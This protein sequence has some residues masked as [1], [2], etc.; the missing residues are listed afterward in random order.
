MNNIYK[1]AVALGFVMTINLAALPSNAAQSSIEG[2]AA[3]V[4]DEVISMYD[5]AQRMNLFFASSGIPKTEENIQR[6]RSQV[7]RKL[8]DEKMQIQ[9][10]L[11]S[12]IEISQ[13]EINNQIVRM[14]QQ[15]GR[16]LE[17]INKF[18]RD[19]GIKLSAL[20][21]QIRAEIA[22]QQYVRRKYSS[23][24]NISETEID[25]TL[26]RAKNALN[27]T[28]Y[29][30]S[31]ILLISN[32]P[33]DEPQTIE[34]GNQLV[35]ELQ[36]GI[37]FDSVARQFSNATSAATGGRIGW[38]SEDQLDPK[39][40]E[41]VKALPA[42]T[43]SKP[44]ITSAGIYIL[45]VDGVQQSGGIDPDKHI[46]DLLTLSFDSESLSLLDDLERV[47]ND[48]TTCKKI[49][50]NATS[51]NVLKVD[52]TGPRPVGGYEGPLKSLLLGLEAGEL[53]PIRTEISTELIIVCD[54]KDDQGI[55]FSREKIEDNI[56][57]QR[58][59][60]MSRRQLRELRKD[61]VVEY[62]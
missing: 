10:A 37:N 17:S 20:E 58:M 60:M 26:E 53:A 12:E 36:K 6:L 41:V 47:K 56:Y 30:V 57:G 62:R 35:D 31:E 5:V 29:N 4:N 50:D 13:S 28:R 49:E 40:A 54:R 51:Y 8:V 59:S 52:R 25:E 42:G 3:I 46:F 1:F 11:E 23:S 7:L 21:S 43:I 16:D 27:S 45:K 22:W 24:I 18:L 39:L 44:I 9:A 61:T 48:F 38:V 15:N 19:N 14:A 33:A 34:L 55:K 32:N 2:I